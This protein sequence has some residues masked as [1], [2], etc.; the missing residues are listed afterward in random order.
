[1]PYFALTDKEVSN[2]VEFLAWVDKSGRSRIPDDAVHW[3][4]TY[5]LNK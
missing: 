4:G 5:I 3:S 1:M 2:L